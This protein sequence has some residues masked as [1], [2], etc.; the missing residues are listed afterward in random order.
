MRLPDLRLLL[1]GKFQHFEVR[2]N[3]GQIQVY[4]WPCG[5]KA[6]GGSIFDLVVGP[7]PDHKPTL[8]HDA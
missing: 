4:Q 3:S 2:G 1:P 8:S 7:C 6:A 5:C